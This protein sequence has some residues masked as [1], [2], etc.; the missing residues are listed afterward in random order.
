MSCCNKTSRE[1]KS[2]SA[3]TS[4]CHLFSFCGVG[5][6]LWSLYWHTCSD[7]FLNCWEKVSHI[8]NLYWIAIAYIEYTR[9]SRDFGLVVLIQISRPIHVQSVCTSLNRFV[10]LICLRICFYYQGELKWYPF[11]YQKRDAIDF[12]FT[13]SPVFLSL[14]GKFVLRLLSLTRTLFDSC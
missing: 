9:W 11:C 3:P 4:T 13:I 12:C 2:R 6:N 14:Y 5:G 10:A 8:I 7:P 1:S